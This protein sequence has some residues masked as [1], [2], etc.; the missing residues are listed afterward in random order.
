MGQM[1]DNTIYCKLIYFYKQFI[2]ETV[3]KINH[4]RNQIFQFYYQRKKD[5]RNL[6]STKGPIVKTAMKK[7][8]KNKHTV[9]SVVKYGGQFTEGDSSTDLKKLLSGYE[10]QGSHS[11]TALFVSRF[12]GGYCYSKELASSFIMSPAIRPT[13]HTPTQPTSFPLLSPPPPSE[14][15]FRH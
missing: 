7:Q 12:T 3:M 13:S 14:K 15:G 2:F 4:P 6:L 1:F 11:T 9:C 5:T 8:Q 10:A